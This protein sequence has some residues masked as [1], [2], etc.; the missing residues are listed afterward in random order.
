MCV[1]MYMH[2]VVYNYTPISVFAP[3]HI[4]VSLSLSYLFFWSSV[5]A[6]R[7]AQHHI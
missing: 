5:C 6:P 7:I 3:L 4:W 1:Y 2:V